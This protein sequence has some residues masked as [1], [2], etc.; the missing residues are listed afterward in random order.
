MPIGKWINN[1]T[2]WENVQVESSIAQ[3]PT[4]RVGILL[5]SAV[6]AVDK[7]RSPFLDEMELPHLPSWY[8][9]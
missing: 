7:N 2:Y 1:I 8:A 3:E 5:I 4:A 6:E 9:Q